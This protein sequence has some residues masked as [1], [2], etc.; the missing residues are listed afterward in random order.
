MPIPANCLSSAKVKEGAIALVPVDQGSLGNVLQKL[1]KTQ[2]AWVLASG[3][4]G[5]TGTFV[6]VAGNSGAIA[7]ILIGTGTAGLPTNS[8]WWLAEVASKLPAGDYIFDASVDTASIE[9]GALGWCLAHYVFDRYKKST[10]TKKRRLIGLPKAACAEIKRI[11]TAMATVRDLVNTPAEDMGPSDLQ[12]AVEALAETFGATSETIVGDDLLDHNFPAIHAVGRAAA[13]GREPR[14]IDLNWGPEDAPKL[15]L[16]GKGVCFDSGGLDI[17]PSAGM[18]TM[19]KDMGGAAHALAL[20]QLIMASKLKVNLRLLISAVENSISASSY[21]PGDIIDTRKG[22]TVEIGNTDAEGRLVLCDALT[23]A[24]EQPP[25]L[26]L[27]FATLT[28]AA[29]VALGADLPAT[30][31]NHDEVWSALE[32]SAITTQ[33]PLWR[34]PLWPGYDNDLT[35]PIADLSN[36]GGDGF[37]GAITAALYLQHFVDPTVAWVHVDV[38]AWNKKN[39]SGR[40]IGGEAQGL[41]AAFNAV[42]TYLSL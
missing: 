30:F 21:R 9:A 35:S 39:R 31:T 2:Q 26:L 8:P 27:D 15:T 20:A 33:D 29:R 13:T 5:Q 24:C 12:D 22:L 19:K 7:K 16:V 14:L 42:K 10:A 17:K 23:L 41:R 32:I 3:F 25:D 34:M 4:E 38:F 11:A 40:P 37:A 36:V 1:G 18:L 6:A 28:G